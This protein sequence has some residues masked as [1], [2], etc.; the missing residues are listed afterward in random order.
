MTLKTLESTIYRVKDKDVYTQI[1]ELFIL[2]QSQHKEDLNSD[3]NLI[4]DLPEISAILDSLTED[5]KAV[6]QC[7]KR[8]QDLRDYDY[9]TDTKI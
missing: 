1:L 5:L 3:K 4:K 9:E 8:L 6:L 7:A 2:L